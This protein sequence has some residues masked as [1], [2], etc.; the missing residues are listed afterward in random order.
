MVVEQ[1]QLKG[2]LEGHNG[3]VTQIATFT[4]NDKTTVISSSRD[5]TIILWDVDN[6]ATEGESIGRPVKALT[7]HNHFVSDVA[8]SSDGQ[9]ALSGSWDKTLR[10][11]DLTT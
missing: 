5:R 11:W 4:R 3:W 7:G 6:I 1:M 8:I 2:T 9:F 10:L